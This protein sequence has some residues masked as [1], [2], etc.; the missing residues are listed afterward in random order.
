MWPSPVVLV[1]GASSGI[2]QATARVLS[3]SGYTVFGTS[4]HPDRAEEI[5]GVEMLELDVRSDPSV[6]ACVAAVLERVGRVDALLNNAG[7]EFSGALEEISMA[8]AREQFETN[9]FGVHR[10][11]RAILP[12]MRRQRS[13]R[14]LNVSSLA[15][16][17]SVPYL[18]MYSASKFALEGYSEALRMELRP[19]GI[20]VSQIEV[21]FLNTPMGAHRRQ[22]ADRIEAYDGER[23]SAFAVF[24]R[25]EERGPP[26]EVIAD[27]VLEI[28]RSRNPRLRYVVGRQARRTVRLR[29]YLPASLY[30]RG[31]RRA[32]RLA[33][34][35]GATGPTR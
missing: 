11:V 13:G 32:F 24:L 10:M 9:F 28:L 14:I 31:L 12:H 7:V 20:H 22:A 1:T 17:S 26:A 29:R 16:L 25:D 15:G 18:G 2:G 6:R 34:T 33:G 23:E 27:A 35:G 8:E 5:P 19:F 21:G 3:R 4:R 30:E